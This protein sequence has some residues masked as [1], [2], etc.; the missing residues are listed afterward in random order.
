[1]AHHQ[2]YIGQNGSNLTVN[3]TAERL[4]QL[5]GLLNQPGAFLLET[6]QANN[7]RTTLLLHPG[8]GG[9]TVNVGGAVRIPLKGDGTPAQYQH[10]IAK[11]LEPEDQPQGQLKRLAWGRIDLGGGGEPAKPQ[12]V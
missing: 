3:L 4:Q 7:R 6:E 10:E 1:M 5:Y 11:W 2:V 12:Q 9:I 8:A